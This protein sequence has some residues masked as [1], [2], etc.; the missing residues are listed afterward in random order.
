MSESSFPF[1]GGT[2]VATAPPPAP[3]VDDVADS[4]SKLLLLGGVAVVVVLAVVGYFLFFAGG[5]PEEPAGPSKPRSIAP[6]APVEPPAAEPA[7]RKLNAKSFGRD[8]FK[9]LIVE[10][11]AAPVTVD[12]PVTT[13]STGSTG[14]TGGSST[15]GTTPSIVDLG[16]SAP[17]ASTSHSFR[18]VDVAPDNSSVTVKVDGETYRNLRAGEVFATYF[19][20]VLISG[21]TNAFQYG[22]EKFNVLGTKRLTIA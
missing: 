7:R 13:G 1:E 10:A 11:E 5:S 2:A 21:A 6:A 19:K 17:A 22:E 18:V 14:S 20:V 15:T 12:V 3:P 4:R 9:A 16:T 8:P